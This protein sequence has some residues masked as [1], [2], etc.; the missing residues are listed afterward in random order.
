MKKIIAF[1]ISAIMLFA[2]MM[3]MQGLAAEDQGFEKAIEAVK[4]KIDIPDNFIFDKNFN[5]YTTE[6]GKRIWN[7][8]WNSKDEM[9]GGINVRV[10]DNGIIYGYDRYKYYDYNNRKKLPKI[11]RQEAV[12]NAEAFI[13]RVNP[14]IASK[15][16]LVE[17]PNSSLMEYSYYFNFVRIEKG[18]P[19]YENNVSVS[20]DRDSGEVLSY[21]YNWYDGITFPAPY[22]AISQEAAEKA[23]K[24]KMGLKLIYKAAYDEDGVRVY[25]AYV[26]SYSDSFAIDALTGEMIKLAPAY[27]FYD[28]GGM[29]GNAYYQ[30]KSAESANQEV[31]LSP[32]EEEA[33]EEA[34]K[35]ISRDEAEKTARELD[36]L[37]LTSDYKLNYSWL[38]RAW[39]ERDSFL[40]NLEFVK[41]S[42]GTEKGYSYISVTLNAVT[43]ELRGFYTSMPYYENDV[44]KYDEEYARKAAEDFLKKMHPDK[45]SETVFEDTGDENI[46]YPLSDEKPRAYYFTY[47]R[48][49]NGIA[50]PENSLT[51]GFDAVYGK[52]LSFSMNWFDK[53]EFPAVSKSASPDKAYETLFGQVGLELQYKLVYDEESYGKAYANPV[54][55]R[56]IKL[57]YS[58]K[59]DKPRCFDPDTG[60]MLDYNG[61]PY[62]EIKPAEYT[63]IAGH[64]AEKQIKVLAEYGVALEGDKFRPDESI[65]QKDFLELLSKTISYYYGPYVK[66]SSSDKEIE[67][68]YNFMIREGI[69]KEG[70][71][72]PDSAISKE[73][74]VKFIIR[75]L[76]FDKVADIKGIY[77]C[78]F[79][80][81]DK[82]NPD[83]IGYVAIA[84]GL[85]IVNGSNGFFNPKA[86][87]TRAQAAIIIYNYLQV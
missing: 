53:A 63:D 51:V 19:F 60:E 78:T 5:V 3:P 87:L 56:N 68:L 4:A 32:E 86:K 30:M 76:K 83:L 62:K 35:I 41:E 36:I 72:A 47:T 26:P 1:V 81:A 48:Y 7:L 77:N 49:V 29:G 16:K 54:D 27:R 13:S 57:V 46:I 65:T 21:Y 2:A 64:Y 33:A 44:P 14:D 40:Y 31:K 58:V 12:R 18:V 8:S 45:F 55:I 37:G 25:P 85:K 42:N 74:S 20:V 28:Y 11:S 50:F 10:D 73:E 38:S 15:I 22:K 67:S 71:K 84:Q 17:N 34:S 75:A 69:V 6:D 24:E 59:Y 9:E 23:Y 43:R 70:E 61:K 80:D 66:S 39:P 79:K 52:I 82:I